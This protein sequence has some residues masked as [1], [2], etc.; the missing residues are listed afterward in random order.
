M[1]DFSTELGVGTTVIGE[2]IPIGLV[3]AATVSCTAD[4]GDIS[5]G[6]V[7]A[8]SDAIAP[9]TSTLFVQDAAAS[10]AEGKTVTSGGGARAEGG[11][12]SSDR[13]TTKMAGEGVANST[14]VA[15]LL[16]SGQTAC[17]GSGAVSI[18]GSDDSA[19]EAARAEGLQ[20]HAVA[21]GA[22]AGPSAAADSSRVRAPTRGI[23][24][25]PRAERDERP[26]TV[27]GV[28]RAGVARRH[29]ERRPPSAVLNGGRCWRTR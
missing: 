28:V 20:T 25:A 4:T 13:E 7:G 27:R 9:S 3:A 8:T 11:A 1:A 2:G 5:A 24:G 16:G 6:A 17:A 12:G 18:A 21:K 15:D 29:L 14:L 26:D 19:K 10:R 22:S 23:G